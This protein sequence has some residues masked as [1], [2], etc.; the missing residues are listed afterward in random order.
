MTSPRAY[1]YWLFDLDGTLV[2]VEWRYVR[3][4]FDR[5]GD[6]LGRSFTD[7]QAERLWYGFT[8]S[9]DD[10]LREWGLDRTAFWSAFDEAEDAAER[11]EATYLHD[12][13]TAL[14]DGLAAADR[15]VGIV[16]HCASFLAEPVLSHLDVRDRFGT[17]VCCDD[18]LGWKPD[19]A[20][21]ERAMAD[22]GVDDG[23]RGV[24][25]GDGD[26]DVGAAWNAGLDAV[27]VER[28][29]PERRG[30]CV[31]A[32]RRVDSLAELGAAARSG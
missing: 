15:P 2:D 23:D 8:G 16:T 5:V 17:V 25:L 22:L 13:A 32:D 9:R 30:R 27:H 6:A 29:G 12:D 24:L 20:P 21:V 11:A 28:H 3:G 10:Q 7:R 1:D 14:L 4:V 19:P 31:L 26:A 18:D